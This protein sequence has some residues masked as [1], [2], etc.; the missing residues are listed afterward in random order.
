M[1]DPREVASR[2]PA[3]PKCGEQHYTYVMKPGLPLAVETIRCAQCGANILR[4]Y[5]AAQP[6][7]FGI[8]TSKLDRLALVVG[9]AL[10]VV[11][12]VRFLI[13]R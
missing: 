2:V 10:V 8:T 3:C 12:A 1:I 5:R 9:V 4:A 13:A 6:T 7:M 11:L